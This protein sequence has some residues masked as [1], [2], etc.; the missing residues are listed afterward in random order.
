MLPQIE[1]NG[2]RNSRRST[3]IAD[4]SPN[5]KRPEGNLEL[6]A[7]LHDGLNF[8]DVSGGYGCGGDEVV[9][10]GYVEHVVDFAGVFVV[11]LV[12]L[13]GGGYDGYIF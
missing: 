5:R 2:P 1:P 3:A 9:R 6:V 11:V 12:E 10:V 7:E 4:V 8:S 13:G